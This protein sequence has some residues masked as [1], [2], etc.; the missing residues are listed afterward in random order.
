MNKTGLR[1]L[2]E[3]GI[4]ISNEAKKKTKSSS[5]KKILGEN[6]KSIILLATNAEL[7]FIGALNANKVGD[8]NLELEFLKIALDNLSLLQDT[9]KMLDIA[10]N[11]ITEIYPYVIECL[12]T[13]ILKYVPN[14]TREGI[15]IPLP[16]IKEIE[17]FVV[18]LFNKNKGDK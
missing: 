11:P 4:T 15:F 1:T 3:K 8:I 9:F 17:K 7:F 13:A 6:K 18:G 2:Y 16:E 12:C 14:P 10:Y 5:R